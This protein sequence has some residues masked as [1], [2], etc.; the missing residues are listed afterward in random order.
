MQM[1][2][3]DAGAFMSNQSYD[4][5][6]CAEI[7]FSR[8]CIPIIVLG[9]LRYR[10]RR[11]ANGGRR[12]VIGHPES[13]EDIHRNKSLCQVVASS[14]RHGEDDELYAGQE[15]I[16]KPGPSAA[17]SESQSSRFS[18]AS[19]RPSR[20][21]NNIWKMWHLRQSIAHTLLF[22]LRDDK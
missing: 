19:S 5:V 14:I 12:T 22:L 1:N 4:Q 21:G 11:F 3:P 16:N 10:R 8:P 6:S 18:R 15:V 2:A 17:Q 9:S 7:D 13:A 20:I